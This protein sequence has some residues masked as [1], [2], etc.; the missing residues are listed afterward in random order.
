VILSVFI[1][2]ED[3]KL[4]KLKVLHYVVISFH[5]VMGKFMSTEKNVWSF[6]KFRFGVL[7]KFKLTSYCSFKIVNQHLSMAV[8]FVLDLCNENS[9]FSVAVIRFCI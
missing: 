6:I 4:V 2:N 5:F 8:I 1:K 9:I 7:T 3:L